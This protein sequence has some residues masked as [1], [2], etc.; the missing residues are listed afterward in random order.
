MTYRIYTIDTIDKPIDTGIRY[1]GL[2]LKYINNI[3]SCLYRRFGAKTH[4]TTN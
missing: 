4:A 2:K 1:C 3:K